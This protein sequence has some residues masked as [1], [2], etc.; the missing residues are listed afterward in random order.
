[1]QE[2]TVNEENSST[3][4]EQERKQ[5]TNTEYKDISSEEN[6]NE[7]IKQGVT[8][9]KNK[10]EADQEIDTNNEIEQPSKKGFWSRLFGKKL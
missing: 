2:S 6:K 3:N 5:S 1:M 10:R 7:D 4:K 9:V 8:T